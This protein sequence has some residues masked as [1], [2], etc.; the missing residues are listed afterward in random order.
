LRDQKALSAQ[1]APLTLL[2]NDVSVAVVSH[3]NP[4]VRDAQS[5]E[6]LL[7]QD[8]GF[9]Y[10]RK[11]P[12]PGGTTTDC[13]PNGVWCPP[14]EEPF[15]NLRVIEQEGNTYVQLTK[16]SGTS[17]VVANLSAQV[18]AEPTAGREIG[19]TNSIDSPNEPALRIRW[20]NLR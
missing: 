20:P 13:G 14:R 1:L 3:D 10:V 6:D 18:V 16:L 2:R 5:L 8:I 12:I 9:V 11:K 15:Y 7:S 19:I 17:Q 4:K